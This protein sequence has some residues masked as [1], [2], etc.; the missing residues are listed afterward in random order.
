MT[1]ETG[2]HLPELSIR[3]F[4]GLGEIDTDGIPPVCLVTGPPG[5]G[6]SSLLDA[7]E[8]YAGRGN[9]ETL[10]RILRNSSDVMISEESGKTIP[11]RDAL[12]HQEDSLR[13]ISISAGDPAL[14]VRMNVDD[15]DTFSPTLTIRIGQHWLNVTMENTIDWRWRENPRQEHPLH[16]IRCM[17]AGPDPVDNETAARMWDRLILDGQEHTVEG[18]LERVTGTP[19]ERIAY[20]GD[21]PDRRAI[22]RIRDSSRVIPMRRLGQDAAAAAIILIALENARDG[23]LLLDLPEAG[24]HLD[25]VRRLTEHIVRAAPPANTQV[26]IATNHP[27]VVSAA[28]QAAGNLLQE[29]LRVLELPLREG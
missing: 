20:I 15:E 4:R 22:A 21:T 18:A 11:D 26:F 29:T 19:V 1:R 25:T 16:P 27:V 24:L 8:V 28:E 5:S 6:K 3:N 14:G 2:I 23:I 12:F 10:R 7:V 17:R 9:P 13:E